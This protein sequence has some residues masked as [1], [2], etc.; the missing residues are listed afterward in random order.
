MGTLDYMAPEQGGDSH[1]VDARADIYSLGATLYKLLTGEAIYAGE[2]Y[3]TPMQKLTALAVATAPPIQERRAG[4][5]DEVAVIVQKMIAKDRE[6]RY[7]TAT[8]VAAALSPYAGELTVATGWQPVADSP[9][10]PGIGKLP[11]PTTTSTTSLRKVA[12][13]YE[14]A[15]TLPATTTGPQNQP[16]RRRVLIPIAIAAGV[17]AVIT[18]A[19]IFTFRTPQGTVEIQLAE[20]V[21][22]ESVE[23]AIQQGGK[24]IEVTDAKQGWTVRLQEGAYQL[25]LQGATDKFELNRNSVSVARGKKEIVRITQKPVAPP[26]AVDAKTPVNDW[27]NL[28]AET[29]PQKHTLTGTWKRID[30]RLDSD[31]SGCQ[32]AEVF[33]S[34]APEGSYRMRR[35]VYAHLGQRSGRHYPAHPCPSGIFCRRRLRQFG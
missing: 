25:D 4:I 3:A 29:D 7:A 11:V 21:D 34:I 2:K 33:T 12:D 28:I 22:A 10:N 15:P 27:V 35:A 20:G 30:G 32:Y 17:V 31:T 8:E 13:D 26:A 6:D 1:D 23:V 16:A 5:S 9:S 19:A 14:T 18:L 24:I